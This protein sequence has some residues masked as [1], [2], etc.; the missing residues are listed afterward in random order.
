MMRPLAKNAERWQEI[1]GTFQIESS[2]AETRSYVEL[3]ECLSMYGD[4]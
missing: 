2:R 1:L 4:V 3:L